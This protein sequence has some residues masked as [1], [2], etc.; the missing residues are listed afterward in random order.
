MKE[1]RKSLQK[2]Y[3]LQLV[4]LV[5]LEYE[6]AGRKRLKKRKDAIEEQHQQR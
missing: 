5:P 4:A 6:P 2:K 3:N 1:E